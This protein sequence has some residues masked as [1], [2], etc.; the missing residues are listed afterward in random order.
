MLW[1]IFNSRAD[2]HLRRRGYLAA[3]GTSTISSFLFRISSKNRMSI[4][5]NSEVRAPLSP[6]LVG[7]WKFCCI[8]SYYRNCLLKH[9][10]ERHRGEDRSDGKTKET[11]AA[12]EWPKGTER[13]LCTE[14]GSTRSLSMETR[15]GRCYGPVIGN[16]LEWVSEWMN[17][18]MNLIKN[19]FFLVWF[20]HSYLRSFIYSLLTYLLTYSVLRQVQSLLQTSSPRQWVIV[21]PLSNSNISSS[22]R[23]SSS[24]LRLLSHHLLCSTFSS[25][26]CFRRYF[27]RKLWLIHLD[28]IC[29]IL[30]TMFLSFQ[31]LCNTSFFTLLYGIVKYMVAAQN[32]MVL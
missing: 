13:I 26:K 2:F 29:F 7:A 18:W 8:V 17:E 19:A 21:F 20:M 30:C 4:V 9:V 11:E 6:V 27:L 12:T 3:R 1:Q 24:C 32:Y 25:I 28:S 31:I 22:L 15:F 23:P 10:I 5:S 14:R 16:T